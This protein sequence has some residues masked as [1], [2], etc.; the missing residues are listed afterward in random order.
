VRIGAV[1]GHCVACGGPLA[2]RQRWCLQC[3]AGA[4]IVVAPTPRWIG[5][6]VL[7]GA[8]GLVALAGVGWALALVI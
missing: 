5:R 1:A 7:A 8:L 6:A 4:R 2:A 3:G